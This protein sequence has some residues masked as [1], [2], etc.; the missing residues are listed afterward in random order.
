MSNPH[1]VEFHQLIPHEQAVNAFRKGLGLFV[2]RG[3]RLSIMQVAR[4]AGVHNRTL[5]CFKAYPMGHPDHRPLD[6]G[7]MLSISSVIGADFTNEW[8]RLCHQCAFDLPDDEP[9][10]GEWAAGATEDVAT[11]L[12]ASQSGTVAPFP[13]VGARMMTRGAQLLAMGGRVA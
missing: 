1:A 5:E 8:L 7:Q 6:F 13:E 4:A 2:G 12:R 11:V 3:R 9:D 10:P